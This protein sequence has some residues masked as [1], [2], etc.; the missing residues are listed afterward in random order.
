MKRTLL[1]LLIALSLATPAAAQT[2]L[3]PINTPVFRA[4][5]SNG[6]PLAG[7]LLYSYV[8]GT[9]TPQATYTDATGA[10]PNTNPVVLDSTG[11]AKVFLGSAL[12]YKFVLQNSLGVQQ[13]TVDQISGSFPA[14]AAAS[15]PTACNPATQFA[16][17]ISIG[18][19][20]LC[21]NLPSTTTANYQTVALNG[22]GQTQRPTLNFSTKFAVTDSS[23]PAQTNID[24]T[25]SGNTTTLGSTSGTFTA[26]HALTTDANHNIIDAGTG[27]TATDY[28]WTFNT[29]SNGTGQPSRCTGTLTLPGAMPDQFYQVFCQV[30]P[31]SEVSDQVIVLHTLPLPTTSG[32]SINYAMV[33]IMQNG[34]TGGVLSAGYCHAHHS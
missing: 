9:T 29:C 6:L 16:Y 1:S 34:T 26:G 17:G 3:L 5:D 25:V 12:T 8:A 7:G 30:N 22:A 18:F 11:S 13:W 33:Q 27:G 28:Y 10:T 23:S 20:A 31:G 2:P 24:L 19:N 32:A 4:L 21:A 14:I 15:T